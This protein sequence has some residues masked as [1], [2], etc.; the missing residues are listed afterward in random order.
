MNEIKVSVSYE[1]PMTNKFDA[2][3]LEYKNAKKVADEIVT[4]YKPLADAAEDAKFDAIM[5]QL[6]TIKEYARRISEI[7]NNDYSVRINV[8]ITKEERNCNYSMENSAEF[9]VIYSPNENECTVYWKGDRFTKE[10]MKKYHSGYCEGY[11][12]IIG[13][14]D[15]WNVY[16]RLEKEACSQL[17]IAIKREK[18]KAQKQI[19]RLHNITKE[20]TQ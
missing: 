1:K 18:D 17:R 20:V 13:K 7:S 12:N 2:L 9:A 4:H 5:E 10:N 15:E 16:E 14:W 19:D 11:N 6:E 3:M 8:F